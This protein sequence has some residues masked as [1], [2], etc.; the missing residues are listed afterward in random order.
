[1]GNIGLGVGVLSCAAQLNLTT[2]AD[3]D[4]FP[5]LDPFVAGMLRSPSELQAA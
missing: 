5:D 3:R 2:I 4:G 1:M